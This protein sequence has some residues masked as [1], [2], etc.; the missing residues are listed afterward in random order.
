MLTEI[1][2]FGAEKDLW[3]HRQSWWGRFRGWPLCLQREGQGLNP[4][5]LW[6]PHFNGNFTTG[7]CEREDCLFQWGC[8]FLE[9]WHKI[10]G[11]YALRFFVGILLL[12]WFFT[13]VFL[14]F[15][16]LFSSFPCYFGFCWDGI[17]VMF[18]FSCCQVP[19]ATPYSRARPI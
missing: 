11:V 8:Y 16:S 9:A 15:V 4:L 12:Y 1:Q 6:Y 5:Q 7:A 18:P 3:A 2:L 10:L 17:L 13:W 14:V 19:A